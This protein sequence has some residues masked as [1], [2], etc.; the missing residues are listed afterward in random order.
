MKG[1][2][3]ARRI[4]VSFFCVIVFLF[5][6]AVIVF[7]VVGG[8]GE[9]S[10]YRVGRERAA[11]LTDI[12]RGGKTYRY[13]EDIL[14]FLVMGIDT[15]DKVKPAEDGISGGQSDTLLLLVLDPKK[16]ELT[17]VGINRDT[18]TDIDVYDPQGFFLGTFKAQITL[19][20][21]YGDGMEQSCERSVKAVSKLFHN[22]PIHGYCAFNMGALPILNDAVG[23]VTV[24]VPEDL[25]AINFRE[26][27]VRFL[28][29]M[30]VYWYLRARDITSF[31]SAGRRLERQKQ[32]LAA[33]F[34]T[35]KRAI[36]KDISLLFRMY[37]QLKQ[38]M[39]TDVDVSEMVYLAGAALSLD[40]EEIRFVSL[41]GTT[42]M[43]ESFEEFYLD[44]EAFTDLLLELFYEEAE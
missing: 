26:G 14:S 39:V 33:F 31:D 32:Y 23:G 4:A 11:Q 9:R 20:H 18:I 5:L 38:Y 25:P 43:G 40:I 30:D 22:L 29:N 1:K 37:E 12:S 44:E 21:G 16:K 13:N 10:L 19:Q 28:Q 35:A 24:T 42:V 41:P 8:V 17:V 2:K 7:S 3:W 36:K 27:E 34:P 15:F 6:S